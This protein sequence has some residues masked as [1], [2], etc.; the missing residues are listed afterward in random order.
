VTAVGHG[1]VT[2]TT[3]SGSGAHGL[4]VDPRDRDTVWAVENV[5]VADVG[6]DGLHF[7]MGDGSVRLARNRVRDV[8]GSGIV[9]LPYLEQDVLYTGQIVEN[10]IVGVDA[11]GVGGKSGIDLGEPVGIIAVLIAQN[12]LMSTAAED[13]PNGPPSGG[14][15]VGLRLNAHSAKVEGNLVQGWTVGMA[16][17]GD[18]HR[19]VENTLSANR[20]GDIVL[21]GKGHDVLQN[22]FRGNGG[23]TDLSD[24]A[25]CRVESNHFISPTDGGI[26][27]LTG[28]IAGPQ[29]NIVTRNTF[30]GYELPF[31]GGTNGGD[32]V[33]GP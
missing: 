23:G 7:V 11:A 8:G 16:I 20:N 2:D 28:L 6:G 31:T 3:I 33:Y 18:G 5:D 24:A 30:N 13:Y 21:G 22:L 1:T 32:N 9:I 27:A 12:K 17:A 26:F 15:L 25:S 14:P 10:E 19:V 29:S 4:V